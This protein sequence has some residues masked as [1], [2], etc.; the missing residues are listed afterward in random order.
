MLIS[1]SYLLNVRTPESDIDC[2]LTI[3]SQFEDA[4]DLEK[5]YNEQ[6]FGS[7]ECNI[8]KRDCVDQSFYCLLCQVFFI[9]L[10]HGD[11]LM[12]Q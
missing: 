7:S 1:G 5:I 2:I 8:A 9:L 10:R 12:I 3:P 6:F 11:I 4:R